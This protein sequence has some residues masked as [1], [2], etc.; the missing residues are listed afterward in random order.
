MNKKYFTIALALIVVSMVSL[1]RAGVNSTAQVTGH[2]KGV[3]IHLPS[4]INDDYFAG[5]FKA[6]VD[7][8]ETSL[9]CIDLYHHLAYNEDYQDVEATNDTLAYIL[10]NYYPFKTNYSP[11]LPDIKR[12]AAAI[13]LT[14]WN[15]TDGLD[16]STLT[17]QD[18]ANISDIL[19]RAAEIKADALLNAHSFNLN[20]FVINI[21]SQSFTI[22][23]LITFTVQAFNEIGLAMPDVQVSLSTTQGTLS[24]ATVTTGI[25]GVSPTV[26]LTPA[27]GQ[28]TAAIT[29]TGIVGIPSGTKYYHVA[30][31]N[32]KQKLILAKPTT[33]SRTITAIVNWSNSFNLVL[34]KVADKTIVNDGD[35]ITYTIKV[36]NTGTGNAQNVQVSDQLASVLDFISSIPSGVYNPTTGIWD[37]GT[38]NANDSTS[39][40]IKVKVNYGNTSTPTYDL[41]AATGFNLFVL[42]SLTQ[43][44]ADTEGKVAVGGDA[45]LRNYSVGDKLPP[46]SGDVLVVGNHLTFISGR[47][48]NGKALYGNFITSTTGFSAD[49]GI[50]QN[51]VIDFDA[52]KIHLNNLSNQLATL[53]QTDT[54]KNEWGHVEL[55]GHNNTENVFYVDGA[56]LSAA[57]NFTV[58]VPNNST[59]IVNVSGNNIDW[60]GG[61]NVVGTTKEKVLIN[62]FEADMVRLHGINVTASILAPKTVL[63]FPAGLV[64]G[65]VI[66]RS[67]FGAGQFN[68][69]LFDGTITNETSIANFA[70]V[71]SATQASMPSIIN[72]PASMAKV[73]TNPNSPTGVGNDKVV[74][75]EFNLLQNYPNPFNPAT[76]ISFSLANNGLVNLTVFNITGE[77]VAT[78]VNREYQTGNYTVEFNANNL[79]SGMYLYRLTTGNFVSTKKMILMK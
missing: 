1:L 45:D 75:N 46:H 53:P 69:S 44:S 74:P 31:P 70:T 30:D 65:Q 79:P 11:I 16:L 56:M 52:A 2:D 23:S 50:E 43:P 26:T 36:K 35:I 13:Q 47:V 73:A 34:S 72:V 38:I 68:N 41:G 18:H 48:Y 32:G 28:T 22:G 17:G 49:D 5:T 63:D 21:P 37:A 77:K 15:L 9:Y 10:N 40:E 42:E 14:L 25:T 57:N 29:A 24:Q 8:N 7:G 78:L 20:T 6:V 51:S 33:A 27:N 71:L 60:M 59:V 58:N 3:G 12:E 19:A 76:T 62:F 4:P 39:L 61:F 66:V 67:M 55:V 54:V 64:T